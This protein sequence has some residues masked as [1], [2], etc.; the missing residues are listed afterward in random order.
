M[1]DERR[2]GIDSGFTCMPREK[3]HA[4]LEI[5]TRLVRSDGALAAVAV[6]AERAAQAGEEREEERDEGPKDDPV[7]VAPLRV[8]AAVA[9]VVAG[10][11]EEDHLDDPGDERDEEGE[12]AEE[13]HEDGARAVV[14]GAAEA[15]EHGETRQAG[16]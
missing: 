1:N 6:A 7:R 15:E 13:R 10:D 12:R 11:A 5:A 4:Q 2:R 8:D 9:E 14:G 3:V 16:G